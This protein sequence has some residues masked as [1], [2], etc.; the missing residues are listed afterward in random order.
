MMQNSSVSK[1]TG[2]VRGRSDKALKFEVETIAGIHFDDGETVITW[3]PLSQ[4]DKI[5][6]V[7]NAEGQDSFYASDWILQTKQL[8]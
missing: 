8:I 2:T 3:F 6:T 7:P 5:M 4:I 1:V